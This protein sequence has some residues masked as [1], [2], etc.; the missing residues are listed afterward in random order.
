MMC[1]AFWLL[2]LLFCSIQL[3]AD[4]ILTLNQAKSSVKDAGKDLKNEA[5]KAGDKLSDA[6]SDAKG[7]AKSA[8]SKAEDE[9]SSIV[10]D[11]K[12]MRLVVVLT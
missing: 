3:F 8:G 4:K 1:V 12:G 10:D 6:G 11:V 7:K 5:S 2:C 9:G